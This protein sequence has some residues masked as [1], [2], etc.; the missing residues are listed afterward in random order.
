MFDICCYSETLSP[1]LSWEAD[2]AHTFEKATASGNDPWPEMLPTYDDHKPLV[3]GL[4]SMGINTTSYPWS[5][6]PRGFPPNA[7]PE[8][9]EL[10]L[11]Q[12]DAQRASYLTRQELE[13]KLGELMI[14]PDQRA[15]ACKA[16]LQ[17]LL[18][19]LPAHNGDPSHQRIVFW[20]VEG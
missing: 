10:F 19:A 6:A 7:S 17:E 1:A 5:F 8:V 4:I 9:N 14:L 3:F 2:N 11:H 20:F 16:P 18:S 15:L 12:T 13:G